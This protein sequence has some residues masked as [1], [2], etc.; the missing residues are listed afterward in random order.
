MV[1]T[2]HSQRTAVRRAALQHYMRLLDDGFGPGG[3]V[4]HGRA[5]KGRCEP[6]KIKIAFLMSTHCFS[7][8]QENSQ[9][10]AVYQRHAMLLRVSL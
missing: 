3:T 1:S 2:L 7:Q 6:S 5:A 10:G 8:L 4:R 9:V